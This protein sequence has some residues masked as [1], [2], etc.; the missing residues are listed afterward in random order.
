MLDRVVSCVGVQLALESW[1]Q[2]SYLEVAN[3]GVED[4]ELAIGRR[5][6]R[7]AGIFGHAIRTVGL[8]AV[9]ALKVCTAVLAH[10][11][12]ATL[13]REHFST[14][15]VTVPLVT[16]LLRYDVVSLH[17]VSR[18]QGNEHS[19]SRRHHLPLGIQSKTRRHTRSSSTFAARRSRSTR[20]CVD[21]IHFSGRLR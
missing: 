2:E 3:V 19:R 9:V 8:L 6:G 4:A 1:E 14:L 11:L 17:L 10:H 16:H 18:L 15:V 21:N 12:L 13:T 20:A 5:A 7:R